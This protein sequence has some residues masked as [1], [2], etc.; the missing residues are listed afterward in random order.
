MN[1]EHFVECFGHCCSVGGGC[2][3]DTIPYACAV[4][5]M[6]ACPASKHMVI[7]PSWCTAT[8]PSSLPPCQVKDFA[9][10]SFD[11]RDLLENIVQIYLNLAPHDTFCRA[12]CLD[13]TSYSPEIFQQTQQ[14]LRYDCAML[15]SD[16][17]TVNCV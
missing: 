14:T 12:V 15:R 16:C 2:P 8:P 6:F 9:A 13:E 17:A 10:V 1:E 7:S 11:A 4:R 3:V 5:E